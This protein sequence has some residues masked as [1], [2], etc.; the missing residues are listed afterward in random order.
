MARYWNLPPKAGA[1]AIISI[2]L[3]WERFRKDDLFP[4]FFKHPWEAQQ[5]P[6]GLDAH[7]RGLMLPAAPGVVPELTPRPC[8]AVGLGRNSRLP[9]A[10]QGPGSVSEQPV[11]GSTVPPESSGTPQPWERRKGNVPLG[12]SGLAA[13]SVRAPIRH[14][15]QPAGTATQRP[16]SEAITVR[17]NSDLVQGNSVFPQCCVVRAWVI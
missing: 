12:E 13:P 6:L 1:N 4:Y 8:P 3:A 5:K 15:L 9:R 16:P 17:R 14:R 7:R 10:A 2:V 11:L